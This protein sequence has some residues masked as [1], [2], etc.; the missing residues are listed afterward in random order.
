MSDVVWKPSA[1]QASFLS[2]PYSVKEALY[3]GGVSS[4]KSDVLLLYPVIHKFIDNPR[5]KQVF[6]RRTMPELRNEIVPRSKIYYRRLGATFN[7]QAMCWTFPSGAMIFLGHCENPDDKYKY[8]SMEINLF[9]PD[10]L[11]SFE[12]DMYIY[13]AFQRVRSSKGSGLPAIVRTAATPGNIGHTWV[14]SRFVTPYEKGGKILVG[15]GGNKRI[16]FHATYL[17]N[18]NTDPNYARSLD[19]LPEAERQAKKFGDWSAY[20]GQVFEEFRARKYSDEPDNALHVIPP[21]DI[22]S[23]WPRIVAI[24]WGFAALTYVLWAAISPDGRV[25]IYREQFWRKTKIAEWAPYVKEFIELEQPKLIRL[26]KSA[27]QDRGQEH[28]I[29]QQITE[30]LDFPVELTTSNPGSR[31]AGKMLMHEYFR[32]KKVHKSN[33]PLAPYDEEHAM[34]LLRNKTESEYHH[35]LQLYIAQQEVDN[36]PKVQIFNTVKLLPET[37]KACVYDKNKPED[38]AE[39]DGDDP[40]DDFRYLL[41]I[42]DRYV[43]E[44]SEEMNKVKKQQNFIE[45][46]EK[47]QDWNKLFHRARLEEDK[48]PVAVRRY[49]AN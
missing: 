14:K 41:D 25:Y 3:G 39:F 29:Q 26:C 5:F 33:K 28:T 19:A 11:T 42:A 45:Q 2:V 36:L 32:W 17:D 8:D 40:I 30:A 47:D 27:G 20:T 12:E 38:I 22:P 15:R 21:I 9:T 49:H 44:S 43:N 16:Y 18:P 7:A 35:Y 46:F 48:E 13:I 1:K 34:W 31:V 4:G 37:I 23:Y 6:M 10:E 24:D